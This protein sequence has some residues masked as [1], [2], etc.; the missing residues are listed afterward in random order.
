[1]S[2]RD[3]LIAG[4]GFSGAVIA[5]RLAAAGRKVLVIDRREHIGGNAFDELDAHGVQI[6]RYGPH[7]F[8]TSSDE[9]VAYLS[10]FTAWHPYEHRVLAAVDGGLTPVPINLQTLEDL[11]GRQFDAESAE[12]FLETQAEPRER[13]LTSEDSVVSR[14]GRLVYEKIFLNYTRK[15]WG[16]DP[17]QLDATVAGR[18]PVRFN[19]DD[20]YFTDT[21]QQMPAEGYTAMFARMLDHPNI[22]VALETD[23]RDVASAGFT[24]TVYT[25]PIDEYFDHRFGRLPYRSL[26][27]EFEHVADTRLVQPVA[28]VNFPNEHEYTR[29]TEFKHMTG[30]SFAGTTLCREF[31]SSDGDP[32]YPVPFAE[33]RELYEKYQRAA[34]EISGDVTFAGRLGTYKY[35]NMDQ[36]VAQALKTA[37]RLVARSR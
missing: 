6:H 1:M 14:V 17:S 23:F 36:V 22:E 4:A 7:I 27:F 33:S 8:H 30:Q 18:I 16:R 37:E 25:G 32:Y 35:Y 26:R 12:A 15:Q 19:R 11:F 10:R 13:I 31:P 9:V 20:R 28:T 21:F 29:S 24:H 34:E 5:E 3:V 2:K